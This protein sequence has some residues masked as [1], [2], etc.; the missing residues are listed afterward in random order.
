MLYVIAPREQ[1]CTK[2]L[3]LGAVKETSVS[4]ASGTTAI[5]LSPLIIYLNKS[6]YS[7]KKLRYKCIW[8]KARDVNE[9]PNFTDKVTET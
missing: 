4:P 6:I 9:Q 7:V 8:T 2:E 5:S 3:S 1:N